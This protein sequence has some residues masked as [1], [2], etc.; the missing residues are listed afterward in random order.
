MEG[1]FDKGFSQAFDTVKYGCMFNNA[2][3]IEFDRC[4]ICRSFDSSFDSAFEMCESICD[5]EF[6]SAFSHAFSTCI[7]CRSF[8]QSFSHAFSTCNL[9]QSKQSSALSPS[10]AFVFLGQLIYPLVKSLIDFLN[11]R[12][13]KFSDQK[14]N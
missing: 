9:I 11:Q 13:F 6:D 3:S 4:S 8:D 7:E 2:F 5:A 12:I 10:Q 14:M 1:S